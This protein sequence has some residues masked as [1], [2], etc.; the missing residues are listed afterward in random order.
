MRF[1]LFP[2]V[3][4]FIPTALFAQGSALQP[5]KGLKA[6][7]LGAIKS[8]A[9]LEALIA[10]T[11]EAALSKALKAHAVEILAAAARRPHA[12]FVLDTV[13]KVKGTCAKS[14]TT[15]E[16]LK[17]ALGGPSALFDS[18][19]SVNLGSTELGIK[20]KREVDPFDQDFYVR[21][22]QIDDLE[23]LTI[24]HTTAQNAWLAPLAKLSALK[25]LRIINQSKLGDEGLAQLAGLK[26]LESFG[27]IGTAMTG[28]PFR[29]FPGWNNLKRA[30]FR[31]SRM[32]DAGLT[33][34]C[35][36]F[37]NLESLVLAH[38]HF[39]DAA[40]AGVARLKKLTGLEIGSPKATPKCLQH[41]LGLPLE[42]L[43]LGDGLDAAAGIAIIKDIKTLKRLTL[44]N[45]AATTDD[46]LKLVAGM[47]HLDHLELGNINVPES[48]LPAL[49]EFAFLKSMRILKAKTPF[50]AQEQAMI[51]AVLPAVAIKFE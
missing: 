36:K 38:G 35:E 32:S 37:P 6:D 20:A 21:L 33:A 10:T 11:S 39:S 13:E 8:K 44:T 48:R 5:A 31:G 43:Q 18:L 27:F 25:S 28:E 14:N 16:P 29:D 3:L 40:V 22:G 47:K 34:L 24:L 2:V 9:E 17:Q 50:N 12:D 42:Y 45:C 19:K 30:S 1:N 7:P 26:Q 4:A 51:K 15:P 49:K 23:E 46:D 41:L